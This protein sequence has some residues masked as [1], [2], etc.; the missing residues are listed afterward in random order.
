[1]THL[2]NPNAWWRLNGQRLLVERN[3][4]AVSSALVAM[5]H[6]HPDKRAKVHALWTLQGLGTLEPRTVQTALRDSAWHVREQ[7]LR[8]AEPFL[9]RDRTVRQTVLALVNDPT[10]RVRFQLAFTLGQLKPD[11]DVAAALATLA[12]KDGAS[13]WMQ[14]AILSSALPP[15]SGLM[16][17][18][19]DQ[20]N[21]PP[22]LLS[23]LAALVAATGNEA[24]IKRAIEAMVGGDQRPTAGQME[25]L[26]ALRARTAT[27]RSHAWRTDG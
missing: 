23:R 20:S 11:A 18:L 13:P 19:L 3:A 17:E 2:A 25:I 24:A 10:P 14:T 4:A 8:V 15:T 6:T 7:A 26:G 12:Q 5:A 27:L 1:M 9:D 21:V 22:A 16:L